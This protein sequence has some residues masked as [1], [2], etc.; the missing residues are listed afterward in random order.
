MSD[1]NKKYGLG[2][3]ANHYGEHDYPLHAHTSPIY[4][5]SSFGFDSVDEA[6]DT[7]V[8]VDKEHYVYTR[9]RNP[10]AIALAKKIALLE[11]I[12]LVRNTDGVAPEE[13]VGGHCSASGIG[14]IAATVFSHLKAGD[15]IV[16]HTSLYSGTHKLFT[17]I[18]TQLGMTVSILDSDQ[19]DA[20]EQE[21]SANPATK[22]LYVESPSNPRIE[23][24][25][26]A[27]L[28]DL[29]HRHGAWLVCDNT[30]ATP[31]HQRPL[32]LGADVVIHSTTK[33]LNGHSAAIGGAIVSRH[34]DFVDFWGKLGQTAMELGA[35]PSPADCWQTSLGLKTFALRMER[36]AANAQNV[37][38]FLHSHDKIREV[39][40]PGLSNDPYHAL[41]SRQM[42][43]GF[44]SF[45]SFE[46]DG[47]EKAAHRL[48]EN[49]RLATIAISFGSTDTVV[50]LPA[51][52]THSGVT[53]T[54]RQAAGISDNLIRY[55]VGI[56]E[57]EDLLDDLDQALK[58]V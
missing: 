31:Y 51:M 6:V 46:V 52:M 30:A 29:A 19:V 17:E 22:M 11:G 57:T 2:T 15:H 18:C 45:L 54:D 25:D 5:T 43:N 4:Q 21:I 42:I 26:I 23:L 8:G 55:C 14:A 35:T 7:F 24:Y 28:A 41:A 47:D 48:I 13:I 40:F 10:N 39:R 53:P 58:K 34:V 16:T 49:L 37:A 56:E 33:F 38:D 32:T 44:G 20:W 36:H 50:Q 27:G 9:G 1:L 3:I 12:D